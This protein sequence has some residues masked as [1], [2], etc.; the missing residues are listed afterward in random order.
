MPIGPR[1]RPSVLPLRPCAPAGEFFRP[2]SS[3]LPPSSLSARHLGQP[4][5]SAR[6]CPELVE[7]QP[8]VTSVGKSESECF[9]HAT[10]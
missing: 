7:G 8:S 9:A 4:L 6:D 2:P 1:I 10:H 3:V 5:D